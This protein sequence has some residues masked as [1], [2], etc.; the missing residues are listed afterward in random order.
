MRGHLATPA[1][2]LDRFLGYPLPPIHPPSKSKHCCAG[3]VS[4]PRRRRATISIQKARDAPFFGTQALPRGGGVSHSPATYAGGAF[5]V[6]SPPL[7]SETN[8]VG[9]P[10]AAAGVRAPGCFGAAPALR[11]LEPELVRPTAPPRRH[12]AHGKGTT[13]PQPP[14]V[15]PHYYEPCF[16]CAFPSSA[17][18]HRRPVPSPLLSPEHPSCHPGGGW[19]RE[20]GGRGGWGRQAGDGAGPRGGRGRRAPPR[21]DHAHGPAPPLQ[22]DRHPVP[23]GGGAALRG[24]VFLAFPPRFLGSQ[25]R[26]NKQ[27][28]LGGGYI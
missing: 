7:V 22:G 26:V 18:V 25:G 27:M 11:P 12:L 16:N 13:P 4:S 24:S 9:R 28:R 23:G 5:P 15:N 17:C 3:R 10:P 20:R 8:G 21:P 2:A 14:E 1:D 6:A 19:A